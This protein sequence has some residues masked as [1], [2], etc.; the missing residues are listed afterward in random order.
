MFGCTLEEHEERLLRVLDRLAE[1]S[2]KLSLDKCEFC[3]LEVKYMGHIVSA[4]GIVTD[5]D[6]IKAV[7]Q[8]QPPTHLKSLQ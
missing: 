3:Q 8:W 5:P 6:K 7:A 4:A 2:L 1:V